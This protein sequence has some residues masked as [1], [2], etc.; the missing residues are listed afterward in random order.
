MKKTQATAS[1]KRSKPSP[2]INTVSLACKPTF[3]ERLISAKD[4]YGYLGFAALLPAAIFFMIYLA[5]GIYPFG[6]STV[7]VLDLNGQYSYFFQAL[8]EAVYSGDIDLLYSWSR[9]LGG[10]FMGIY[11]YYLASP[12]SYVV[13]LFPETMIQEAIFLM[14]LI[15]AALCGATMGFYLHKHSERLNKISVVAFSTL[16]ATSAYC[17]VQMNNI[18]WI[19]AVM[20]LPLLTLGIEELVKY[21]KYKMFVVALALTM[22]SNY[23]IGYMCCI[24][25]ALYFFYYMIAFKDDH[26]NDPRYE[27]NHFV[28][29]LVRVIA[30]SALALAISAVIILT[31]YYSLQF[32]KNSFSDPNWEISMRFDF[33]DILYKFLPGSYDTVRPEG[34]P[35]VYCG[36]I[37]LLLVPVFFFSKKFTA[38]EKIASAAL[39]G[40]F[41]LSFVV[42]TLDL[43]W[44]GFQRPNW[45]NARFSFM[46]CFFLLVLAFKAFDR[47]EEVGRKSLVGVAAFI[48]LFVLLLQKMADSLEDANEKFVVDDYATVL[49]TLVCIVIYLSIIAVMRTAKNRELVSTVLVCF[50]CIEVFLNGLSNTNDL[51]SDVTFTKHYKYSEFQELMLPITDTVLDS[52]TSFYRF[53]KTIHRKTNDNM[54]LNIRGLSTSTSTLN[55]DTIYFLRMMGYSSKSH[56]SKYLGG[57]PVSDSLLGIKYLITDRD[58]SNFYGTPVFTGEDYAEHEGMTLE[59]LID[60]TYAEQTRNSSSDPYGETSSDDYVVYQNPYALSLAFAAS[61]DILTFNMKEHNSYVKE[62]DALFNPDGYT[63]PFLRLNGLITAILG[64]DE[65]IEIFKPATQNG[66]PVLNGCTYTVSSGHN[67]YKNSGSGNGTVTYTYTVPANTELYLYFPA[68]YTREVKISSPTQE[69][70]DGSETFNGNETGRI[71]DLGR[72][73]GTE[74]SLTVT[75]SSNDDLFYTKQDPSFI[76]YVDMEVFKDAMTRIQSNQLVIDEYKDD[77]DISGRL[78]TSKADQLIL[79]TIPYDEGWKVYV[80][81]EKVDTYE[82]LDALIAFDIDSAGEHE[83]RFKY[84]PSAFNLGLTITVLASAAFLLIMIFEKRLARI[85]LIKKIFVVEDNAPTLSSGDTPQ[86]NTSPSRSDKDKKTE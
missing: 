78:T 3:K 27:K 15:K 71:I 12:I 25:T 30:F 35:F 33:F 14:Y 66:E 48:G 67:K 79:T 32:G 86:S 34:F 6:D 40:I 62:T 60:K 53:E 4:S 68:Y 21:G 10:E 46:L 59:E 44:H 20:W 13:C 83:I 42:S 64:E 52:D 47:V 80:D 74:Y 45:L 69:I 82:T 54:M 57:N 18:M 81:G 31:A 65:T 8:R 22:M 72:I 17:V 28:R 75:I 26:V 5:R 37:T 9:A 38:R 77:T 55:K 36:V 51:D 23:Y 19:D 41:V 49:L 1:A 70:Y 50:I 2:K 61:Q 63:S 43:I 29:S 56:W 39:I 76:Y 84:S 58:Y 85:R 16:Y 7:L 11:A 24:Y 73:E